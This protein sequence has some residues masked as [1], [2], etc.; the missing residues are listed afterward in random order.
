PNLLKKT[1]KQ[2]AG[3]MDSVHRTA[4]AAIARTEVTMKVLKISQLMNKH[5]ARGLVV[6]SLLTGTFTASFFDNGRAAEAALA[7][8]RASVNFRYGPSTNYSIIRTLK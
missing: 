5:I 7:E 6:V 1:E 8:T 2:L 3:G 4:Q